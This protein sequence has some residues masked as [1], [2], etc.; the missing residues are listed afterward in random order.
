MTMQMKWRTRADT[1]AMMW[2]YIIKHV[3]CE[4]E[5]GDVW[6]VLFTPPVGCSRLLS[7]VNEPT[8]TNNFLKNWSI[9]MSS[10]GFCPNSTMKNLRRKRATFGTVEK[11]LVLHVLL[12]ILGG[13]GSLLWL[14]LG[15]LIEVS[16]E[17]SCPICSVWDTNVSDISNIPL[18]IDGNGGLPV[19][20]YPLRC[21]FP[22]SI[23]F[24]VASHGKLGLV[25]N[26]HEFL[27]NLFRDISSA[28]CGPRNALSVP[29]FCRAEHHEVAPSRWRSA[30]LRKR[31]IAIDENVGWIRFPS[32]DVHKCN[33]LF[34]DSNK[35]GIQ[36]IALTFGIVSHNS[37][38]STLSISRNVAFESWLN[39]L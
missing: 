32:R 20:I 29:Q 5:K 1:W 24:W 16:S 27:H 19:P 25:G 28:R 26:D 10:T 2:V 15:S 31:P 34:L 13:D 8:A 35:E 6:R 17:H 9:L 30:G 37:N 18:W 11:E 39:R 3:R 23:Q 22:P 7:A 21:T 36:S 33:R 14:R 12:L 4:W 38:D